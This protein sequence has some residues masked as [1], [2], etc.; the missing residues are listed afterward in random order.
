MEIQEVKVENH[1]SCEESQ[2]GFG[3]NLVSDQ[4]C[5]PRQTTKDYVDKDH[6]VTKRVQISACAVQNSASKVES[7][8]LIFK[9]SVAGIKTYL[10]VD[11]DSEAKLID[12]S[13]VRTN[14]IS[15]FKFK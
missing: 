2:F 11:N 3:K 6:C 14:K 1:S 15:T 13:F 10:L 5:S 9:A 8:H 12:K 7:K 4:N